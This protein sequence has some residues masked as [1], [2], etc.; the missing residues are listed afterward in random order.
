MPRLTTGILGRSPLVVREEKPPFWWL[1]WMPAAFFTVVIAYLLYVVG[2]VAIV[3][4]VASFG[5][6][7]ILNPLV[8]GIERKAGT[9]RTV[10]A[11]LALGLVTL[12]AGL[13]L[14][15]VIPDLWYQSVDAGEKIF[16]NFTEPNARHV[17]EQIRHFSP[18]LDRLFGYHV[19]QFLRSPNQLLE[20]SRSWAAGGL[21]HFFTT[22]SASLDLFLIPF[23]VYYIL[24]DFPRWRDRS[25]DLI[26]PRFRP[27]FTRLFD[28]VGRILQ[29]YVLGQLMIAM[30]MGGMYALGFFL[31]RV[32]AWPGIAALAGFLNVVPYVGTVLG[33]LLACGFTFAHGGT[34]WRVAGVLAVFIVVQCTEGYFLTPRILG[35]RLSLHPMTVFLGLLIGA[36]MFGFLGILLAVPTIAVGQVFVKFFREIYKSSEFYNAGEM[37]PQPQPKEA[38]EVIAEA[39]ENVLSEQVS[40]QKGD[41]LLAPTKEKDDPAAQKQTA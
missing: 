28:E 20:A 10:S 34:I 40:E 41:E 27:P 14:W 36:K 33:I 23:F 16:S 25:E 37:G 30:M 31:L 12:L 15:F 17:R 2:R 21:T 29:S 18:M 7:Y 6:A 9:S 11:L 32:P 5:L 1:R 22:A 8:E 13:F 4:L 38:P 35:A 3:P 39:A 24:V 19:Y 26:P